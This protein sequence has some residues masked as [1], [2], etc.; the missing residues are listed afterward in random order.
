MFYQ[1]AAI[2]GTLVLKSGIY[3]LLRIP[4]KRKRAAGG[5]HLELPEP[6]CL[7]IKKWGNSKNTSVA[8]LNYIYYNG[9]IM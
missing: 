5:K 2:M 1:K 7:H 4:F 3:A 6:R 9:N 8:F